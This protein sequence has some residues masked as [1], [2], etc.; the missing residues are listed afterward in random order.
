V[1]F[2][3]REGEESQ[4]WEGKAALRQDGHPRGRGT[5]AAAASGSTGCCPASRAR[6]DGLIDPLLP[7][8]R[9]GVCSRGLPFRTV[10]L[11]ST[12]KGTKP[13]SAQ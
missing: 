8:P 3:Q 2:L 10:V 5:G 7:V 11:F 1:A 6:R 12:F 9:S 13:V 4:G